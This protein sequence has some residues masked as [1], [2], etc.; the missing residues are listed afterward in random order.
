ML[1]VL[2]GRIK[3]LWVKDQESNK[4]SVVQ[5]YMVVNAAGLYAQSLAK[6]LQGLPSQTIP[7]A[8]LARGHYCTMEGVVLL[9]FSL[10]TSNL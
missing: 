7:E 4:T 2:A 9:H 3:I 8:F 6:K 10:Q 1:L 5:A